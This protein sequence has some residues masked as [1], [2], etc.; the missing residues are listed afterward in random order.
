MSSSKWPSVATGITG[1]GIL[2]TIWHTYVIIERYTPSVVP[3]MRAA[4]QQQGEI[5]FA[6]INAVDE[7]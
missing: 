1:E 4:R 5:G 3:M 6:A 7:P 2:T